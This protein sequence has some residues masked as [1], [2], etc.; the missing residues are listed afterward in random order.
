MY[1]VRIQ[2]ATGYLDVKEDTAF[3]LNFGVADIRD[4]SKRAGA[5]S[6]TITLVGNKNNHDLLNHYYDVNIVAGTFDINALTKCTVVQNG[7]PILADAFVQ[8]LSVNKIQKDTSF[9]QDIEYSVL[10]KDQAS[11]FFTDIDTKELKDIDYS[12]LNHAIDSANIYASFTNDV[13]DGYKY[14]LNWMTGNVYSLSE[15]RPAIYAKVY[16]DR[17]F[18][19]AGY[20]YDWSSLT[21]CGFDKLI[22]PYSGDLVKIDYSNYAVEATHAADIISVVQTPYTVPFV[23]QLTSFTEIVDAQN[24]F[25]PITGVYTCPFPASGAE[26]INIGINIV[27]DIQLVNA[28]GGDLYLYNTDYSYTSLPKQIYFLQIK[29]FRS[30]SPA[31]PIV[32][33]SAPY[34]VMTDGINSVAYPN[35]TTTLI[36]LNNTY[37][38]PVSNVAAGEQLTFEIGVGV[39]NSNTTLHWVTSAVIVD[40]IMTP[41][42]NYTSLKLT[43]NISSNTVSVGTILNMNQFVPDKI[44]QKDFVKSIFQMFNLYVEID[45]NNPNT[46]ILKTRDDY[47]DS[48]V[49]KDWTYKLAKD[50]EQV[51]NFLPELA[52]K[53]LILT[54]KQDKDTP[55]VTYQNVTRE[56][57]GQV[58]YVFD[59]EYVKGIET[60]ELI[61]SP[62]P[63]GQT[64]FGAYVPIV[65]GSSPKQNIRILY[66]GGIKTCEAYTIIDSGS[67]G[68]Y[69][70]LE[71][72]LFHH[73]DDALNPTL[74][75]NFALCDFMFYDNY[76][77]TDNN[78]YNSYWRRTISQINT[79]NML[80]AYFNLKE[81]DIQKLKLNDKIRIDN[82]WWSINKV[83]DYDAN[84]K[85]LTKVELLSTDSEIDFAPFKTKKPI[86]PHGGFSAVYTGVN[87]TITDNSNAVGIGADAYIKGKNNIV[88]PNV[89][90][91]IEGD[92]FVVSEDGIYRGN[93]NINTIN[94]NYANTDLTFDDN[95]NHS[96]NGFDLIESTDG[97]N[98]LQSFRKMTPT[99]SEY[100][101]EGYKTKYDSTKVQFYADNNLISELVKTGFIHKSS[102]TYPQAVK[103]ANYSF[104][105]SDYLVNCTANSFNV[106]L[107][108][109]VGRQGK[110]YVVKNSGTGTIS[111][112]ASAGQTI[113][114]SATISLAQYD[115][116]VV[117]SDNANWIIIAKS[118]ASTLT[119]A[120]RMVTVGRNATGA[121]LY[122]GTV[123][124]ISGSTGN[125][126]NYVKAQANTEANSAGTFGV[127][128]ADIANNSDGN[129][130]TIGTVNTLDTRSTAPNPFTDVTLADGDTIY[131]HPTIAGYVTNVKPSAPNH[132]VY[133]G[134]VV[135]THPTLGTIVYRIQNGYEL[136]EIHDVAI[137]SP[138]NGQT[139]TYETATSLWKNTTPSGGS[140]LTVGTT[141]ITSGTVGRILFE[142]T[143]NVLQEDSNLFW[144]NTNKRL[145]IGAT[146]STTVRLDVRSQGALS[147]D[148]AFR[149]RNSA[150][151][152]NLF[153]LSGNGNFTLG[154]VS[155][156]YIALNP[157][158]PSLRGYNV[159]N[160]TWQLSPWTGEH[161][162]LTN[163]QS[164]QIQVGIGIT[165]P[166]SKLHVY[167]T[168]DDTAIK[169]TTAASLVAN[170]TACLKF[171]TTNAGTSYGG[172]ALIIRAR[173]KGTSSGD[174]KCSAEFSLNRNG[175]NSLKA[176]ITSQSNLLLQAP[177]EDTND[178]GVIY[179]PNG[180]AP[181]ANLAGGGKLY[182]EGG[183][184][185]YRGSSGTTTVLGVA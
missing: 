108:T 114:D 141:A 41:Q 15:F 161:C 99:N 112:V 26:V 83:I 121:T 109:A 3:P 178:I 180:T 66:D 60:K 25:N 45:P 11:T 76:T 87:Q 80:I 33:F 23:E 131:L 44:K 134:K 12:D 150:D 104:V 69:G 174:Q 113:D 111:F 34:D 61:F 138:T 46:L 67:V 146:P 75:I 160:V 70:I 63:I 172:D 82:S 159:G 165:T 37:T 72:P 123:V 153:S 166:T 100:G 184:L 145:G 59:N 105:D 79:G 21:A 65:A 117:Q 167:T 119:A 168:V 38:L 139:L 49:E 149:V 152:N 5:F 156:Y 151:S 62:S 103:T 13:T 95:R 126:P 102:V 122:K 86:K 8:L 28:T 154:L 101:F 181:T 43:A 32:A 51:L 18:Q 92:G 19:N 136:N 90:C 148:I 147:T 107:P 93:D 130:V 143:G 24:L 97:G 140:G 7:I 77:P 57:Y 177:T 55:N 118:L 176:S 183:E 89:K 6:K 158:S 14:G 132:L 30:N 42:L 175:T 116:V 39:N 71:Y 35:G 47:Y 58:E 164:N 74:D 144:D 142:G 98:L 36:S 115:F 48:G 173:S 171:S 162:W 31:Y 127:I 9:E 81:D 96:T 179:I 50:K 120:D 2:L 182:V 157:S 27:G 85:Q 22:I 91:I 163:N 94:E 10:I 133:V 40:G 106:T 56:I 17:I 54:Y 68:L 16:F 4:V 137:S 128:E 110:T 53:K 185:K 1:N 84:N 29:V 169:I 129:A 64:I 88:M 155:G 135:R 124:Y 78:L 52:S 125:R 20:N 170:E 73:Y